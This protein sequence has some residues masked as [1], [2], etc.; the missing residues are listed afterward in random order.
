MLM[1]KIFTLIAMA[2]MALGAQ[3]EILPD[4]ARHHHRHRVADHHRRDH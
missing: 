1:K 3:A 4:N 2:V